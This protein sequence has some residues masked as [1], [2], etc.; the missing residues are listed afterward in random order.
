MEHYW[1][2]KKILLCR[3]SIAIVWDSR[4]CYVDQSVSNFVIGY[5]WFKSF[6][7]VRFI[8]DFHSLD[9]NFL[10]HS[11]KKKKN[12]LM[13]EI[14]EV[15]KGSVV[16]QKKLQAIEC[17]LI[18][19]RC[20]YSV[21]SCENYQKK[22]LISGIHQW[23]R[24]IGH[25]QYSS[26]FRTTLLLHS[27]RII[28][29][30]KSN[31][32]P[33]NYY[34]PFDYF[35][36]TIKIQ[37]RISTRKSTV[38]DNSKRIISFFL[39]FF[40]DPYVSFWPVRCTE[41]HLCKHIESLWLISNR[42]VRCERNVAEKKEETKQKNVLRIRAQMCAYG[43]ESSVNLRV[44]NV[45][46]EKCV[47]SRIK[48][49]FFFLSSLIR[50]LQ[51]IWICLSIF[52][53]CQ[54]NHIYNFILPS[55]NELVFE[56]IWSRSYVIFFCKIDCVIFFPLFWLKFKIDVE[57]NNTVFFCCLFFLVESIP[58]FPVISTLN[59]AKSCHTTVVKIGE[60]PIVFP[61]KLQWKENK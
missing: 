29:E 50:L 23:K 33:G 32:Y 20:C 21:N 19:F 49:G 38:N 60:K 52:V 37:S 27:S 43:Q 18:A 45:C 40:F 47:C 55:H 26:S 28:N 17:D 53:G 13:R 30:F 58:L 44:W 7:L 15:K 61:Y 48:K 42:I 35:N 11:V 31:V 59:L 16:L 10:A 8:C 25:L 41:I 14:T 12:K 46:L 2:K 1:N 57:S 54:F 22:K 6:G 24:F 39:F 51:Q 4:N 36:I 9:H 34:F 56:F 5:H 3:R